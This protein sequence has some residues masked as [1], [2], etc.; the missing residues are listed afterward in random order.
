MLPNHNLK[1]DGISIIV[2]AYN[3]EKSIQKEINNE[4]NFSNGRERF[5]R[6]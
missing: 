6:M 3:K 1:I 4:N 2:P 5:Y